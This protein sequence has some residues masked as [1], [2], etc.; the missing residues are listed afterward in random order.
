MTVIP[1]TVQFDGYELEIPADENT[2]K[3]FLIKI[4]L[5]QKIL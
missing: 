4:R 5:V 2:V 3:E 1:F